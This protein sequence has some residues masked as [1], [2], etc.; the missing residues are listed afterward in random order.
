MSFLAHLQLPRFQNRAVIRLTPLLFS[1]LILQGCKIILIV[2]EGGSI[3][4]SSGN[5]SCSAGNTCEIDVEDGSEFS[6]TFTAVP[7]AG[8]TF[9]E[10]KKEQNHLCGGSTEPCALINVPGIL[11]EKDLDLPMV[12]VFERSVVNANSN[13]AYTYDDAGRLI[14]VVYANG[15]S[16][17]YQ[18][19]NNGN[20]LSRTVQQ[21]SSVN[22]GAQ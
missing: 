7:D 14:G 18:Y 17:S 16:I 8:Y 4:S 9:V 11:T 19:D 20:L 13:E 10:W 2:P 1:L 12:P 6:D 15:D 22:G 3:V 5:Y 21:A